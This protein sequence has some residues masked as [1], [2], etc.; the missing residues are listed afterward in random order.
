MLPSRIYNR[1]GLILK[2]FRINKTFLTL[3]II[4]KNGRKVKFLLQNR[5][6]NRRQKTV[7]INDLRKLIKKYL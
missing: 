7:S 4:A 6:D 5:E 2:P 1:K 3:E